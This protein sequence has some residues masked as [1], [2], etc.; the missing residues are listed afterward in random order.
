MEPRGSDSLCQWKTNSV[1]TCEMI[2][3]QHSQ[4]PAR[5]CS[6]RDLLTPTLAKARQCAKSCSSW[7]LAGCWAGLVLETVKWIILIFSRRLF[8]TVSHGEINIWEINDCL[9]LKPL[10]QVPSCFNHYYWSPPDFAV[11]LFSLISRTCNCIL[12]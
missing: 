5:P 8:I 1:I 10:R 11:S 3:S 9:Q 4:P 12:K 2:A 6:W 7:R